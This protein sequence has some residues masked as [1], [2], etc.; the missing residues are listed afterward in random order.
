MSGCL[1]KPEIWK[2]PMVG[3]ALVTAM[4]VKVV[5]ISRLKEEAWHWSVVT[6][7]RGQPGFKAVRYE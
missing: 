5:V 1:G 3:Q 7:E 2:E 4:S 6:G